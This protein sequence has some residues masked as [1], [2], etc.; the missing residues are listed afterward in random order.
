[1]HTDTDKA[2]AAW[3]Q[4]VATAT[5]AM[6]ASNNVPP[7]PDLERADRQASERVRQLAREAWAMPVSGP[8]GAWGSTTPASSSMRPSSLPSSAASTTWSPPPGPP[9]PAIRPTSCCLPRSRT[10][11][12]GISKQ[13]PA[14]PPNLVDEDYEDEAAAYLIRGVADAAEAQRSM[15]GSP[16]TP[17]S[18]REA[19]AQIVQLINANPRSPRLEEIEAVIAK[20]AAPPNAD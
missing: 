1:M 2:L 17:L 14:L 15:S 6:Q 4:A 10:T 7:D 12:S 16:G 19:A 3:R 13:F 8:G 11:C 20:V 5:A 9:A 18:I